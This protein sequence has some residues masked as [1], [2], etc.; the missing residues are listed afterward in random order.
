MSLRRW[1]ARAGYRVRRAR[2]G[3]MT[4]LPGTS[5]RPTRGQG[6]SPRTAGGASDKRHRVVSLEVA[7][8]VS[9]NSVSDWKAMSR[10]FHIP[11]DL[12]VTSCAQFITLCSASNLAGARRLASPW[13]GS[14]PAQTQA[15]SRPSRAHGHHLHPCLGLVLAVGYR[16]HPPASHRDV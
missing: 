10:I 7:V 12:V 2:G 16:R 3:K 4:S 11:P 15:S 6:K 13:Q 9:I 1:S 14:S 8:A 5:S